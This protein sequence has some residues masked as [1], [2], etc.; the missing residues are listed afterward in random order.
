[1]L[2][3]SSDRQNP[4][5]SVPTTFRTGDLIYPEKWFGKSIYPLQIFSLSYGGL[6]TDL[7]PDEGKGNGP[8][9]RTKRI[10]HVS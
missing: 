2:G 1:M 6:T 10:L 4:L 8:V 3:R 7:S 5:Q 9:Q